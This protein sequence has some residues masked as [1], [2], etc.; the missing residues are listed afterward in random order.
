MNDIKFKPEIVHNKHFDIYI[1]FISSTDCSYH[2]R[3]YPYN[4][5]DCSETAYEL[6]MRKK[7]NAKDI[8][9]CDMIKGSVSFDN[10]EDAIKAGDWV[11]SQYIAS[12]LIGKKIVWQD[13]YENCWDCVEYQDRRYDMLCP[14][15]VCYDCKH[16]RDKCLKNQ[17]CEKDKEDI[18]MGG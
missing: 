11:M 15:C 1:L 2:K 8:L 4:F 13:N 14:N 6:I 18:V 5:V 9:G 10:E 7:F 17:Y 12:K 3:H 16:D